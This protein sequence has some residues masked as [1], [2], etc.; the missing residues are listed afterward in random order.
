MIF[1]TSGNELTLQL[2]NSVFVSL[3]CK[4]CQKEAL[5]KQRVHEIV[6]NVE[7]FGNKHQSPYTKSDFN[8][9]RKIFR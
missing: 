6:D 9:S 2:N 5:Q 8:G 3:F 1:S 7:T 4:V